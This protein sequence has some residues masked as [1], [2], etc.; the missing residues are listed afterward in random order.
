MSD[1]PRRRAAHYRLGDD[2][3]PDTSRAPD[4]DAADEVDEGAAPARGRRPEDQAL[5]VDGQIRAAIARGDFDDLPLSGKPLPPRVFRHDPDWWLKQLIERENVSGVLP[6][7][8]ALRKED[9]E[10]DDLL[11]STGSEERVREMLADFNRR[12]V[13]ARRQLQGGPPVITA[14]RDVDDEVRAWRERLRR[15]AAARPS[16][17]PPRRVS[18]RDR[19]RARRGGARD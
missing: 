12:V 19:L 17:P 15:R 6:P 2:P 3:A 7:A 8:L 9:A 1:D 4:P 5:Y 16:P 10:L 14:T 11:D 18:W 13:E